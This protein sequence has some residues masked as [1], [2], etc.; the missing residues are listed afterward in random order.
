MTVIAEVCSLYE[1]RNEALI[2]AGVLALT[3]EPGDVAGIARARGSKYEG[4]IVGRVSQE[5]G[6]LVCAGSKDR[7]VKDVFKIG[8][9]I[10]LD[11][12]HTCITGAMYGWHLITDEEDVVRDVYVPWKWW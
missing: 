1:D 7:S 3:R 6:V 4:W 12:Q 8:D 11:V 2:N 10:E 5:H 9:K